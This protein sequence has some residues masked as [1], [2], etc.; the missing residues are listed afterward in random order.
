MSF[1]QYLVLFLILGAVLQDLS[2]GKIFNGWILAGWGLGFWYRLFEPE[3]FDIKAFALGCILPILILWILFYFRMLGAGD[4]KLLSALGG[5][6]GIPAIFDCII[7]SFLFGGLL[8]LLILFCWG[9]PAERIRYF[10]QYFRTYLTT[11]QK[12]PYR[13]KGSDLE[14]IHFSVPVLMAVLLWIGGFY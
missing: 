1:Y 3:G 9:Q 10:C 5:L 12:Q 13:Q 2:F 11:K 7:W 6:L 4:L 14:Q 8:S